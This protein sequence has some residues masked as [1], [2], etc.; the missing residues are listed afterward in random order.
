MTDFSELNATML[1]CIITGCLPEE[2]K[3]EAQRLLTK[4]IQHAYDDGFNDGAGYKHNV[5]EKP[6]PETTTFANDEFD[7]DEL[8]TSEDFIIHDGGYDGPLSFLQR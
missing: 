8:D 7:P 1:S 2:V 3:A 4:A 6:A 5:L